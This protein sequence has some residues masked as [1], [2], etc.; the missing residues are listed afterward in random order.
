MQADGQLWSGL[1]CGL[2]LAGV[3]E[4][5][6]EVRTPD[7]LG[8]PGY[9]AVEDEDPRGPRFPKILPQGL[10]LIQP[11]HEEGPCAGLPQSS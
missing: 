7:A 3:G 9:K 2:H 11:G 10:A 8:G 5:G 4:Y 1:P 6:D